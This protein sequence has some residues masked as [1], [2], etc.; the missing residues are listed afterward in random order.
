MLIGLLVGLVVGGSLGLVA[1]VLA[2]SNRSDGAGL[3][4]D[5][6][7]R[8]RIAEMADQWRSRTSRPSADRV[9]PPSAPPLADAPEVADA[10]AGWG[11]RRRGRQVDRGKP[12]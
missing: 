1:G 6:A 11:W 5:D 3:G 8:A 10:D 12:R 2:A 7:E 9:V 4:A